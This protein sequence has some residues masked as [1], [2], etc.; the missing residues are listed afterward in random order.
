MEEMTKQ[1]KFLEDKLK[2][3]ELEN[4]ELT[5]TSKRAATRIQ[6]N[7]FKDRKIPKY[8]GTQEIEEWLRTVRSF[9]NSKTVSEEEKVNYVLDHLSDEAKLEIRLE[10][11]PLKSTVDE[12]YK[13]LQN[14]YGIKQSIFELQQDFYGR[15]QQ[16]DES[17]SDYSH[18]LIKKL[19]LLQKKDPV[20]YKDTETIL[21]QRFAEGIQDVSLRRELKRLNR[22]SPTLNFFEVRDQ[23][24]NW[25]K[26]AEGKSGVTFDSLLKTVQQQQQQIEK[27][28]ATINEQSSSVSEQ[29][30]FDRDRGRGRRYGG[31]FRGRGSYPRNGDRVSPYSTDS[32]KSPSVAEKDTPSDSRKSPIICHYCSQPNH[33]SPNCWKRKQ[34]RAKKYADSKNEGKNVSHSS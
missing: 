8:D 15:D 31:G 17:L 23:A 6:V 10:V 14:I 1:M 34:D 24:I 13:I 32:D 2:Q 9:V 18:V 5:E 30:H 28:T 3:A 20:M 29:R 26:D 12:I 33:I 7:S 25:L 19:L 21:K 11:N 4:K 16:E 27:L 22:E